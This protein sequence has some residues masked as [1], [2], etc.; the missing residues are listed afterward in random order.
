M[1]RVAVI[2]HAS[3]IDGIASSALIKM[4]YNTPLNYLF[5]SDYSKEGLAYVEKGLSKVLRPRTTLFITDLGINPGLTNSFLGI[6]HKVRKAGGKIF[7]FDHHMWGESEL[8]RIAERCDIAIVG[9][10]KR[11]CA[12]EIVFRKLVIKTRFARRLVE[13]V[14][15]SDFNLD[16]RGSRMRKLIGTYALS[17]TYYSTFAS[18]AAV[19]KKLRHVVDVL[20]SEKFVD[21]QISEDAKRF[22]R[23]NNERAS[24]MLKNLY[25]RKDFAIGFSKDVQS[26]FACMSIIEKAQKDVGIY[27]NKRNGKGHIRSLVSDSSALARSLGGNGHPHASGFTVDMARYK[28]L[29]SREDELSFV[30]YVEKK[31]RSLY[32]TAVS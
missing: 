13:I 16:P 5:F 27:V 25:E 12:T 3:D 22:E 19:N 11:Y 29:R 1:E 2:S 26:T 31:M 21:L 8:K 17:I 18:R 32:Q 15:F 20:S 7:W 9:E 4:K 30:E 10:N 28:N 23:I 14:H 6:I 24:I